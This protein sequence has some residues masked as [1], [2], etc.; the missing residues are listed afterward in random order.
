MSEMA[1][2]FPTIDREGWE[3]ETVASLVAAWLSAHPRY[4][5]GF[6]AF[7]KRVAREEREERQ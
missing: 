4:A 5:A 7:I 3:P 6:E 2:M 1:A